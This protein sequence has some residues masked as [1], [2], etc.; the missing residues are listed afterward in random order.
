MCPE[1]GCSYVAPI[2]EKRGC[3]THTQQKLIRSEGCPVEIVY[4][5]PQNFKKDNRRWIG[6]IVR[7]QKEYDKE[8][9]QPQI[10]R[11][12]QDLQSSEG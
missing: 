10:T 6:G 3:K 1:N 4:I 11:S 5:Y 12:F 2:R 9:S 8:S 7:N